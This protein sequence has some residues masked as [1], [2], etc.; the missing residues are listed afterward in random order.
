[1]KYKRDVNKVRPH[2]VENSAGQL[3]CK[4][5]CKIII[6]SRWT[7]VGLASVGL[8]TF[9]YGFFPIILEETG[10]Y[11]VSNVPALIE[12]NPYQTKPIKIDDVE[13]LE[14]S[15]EAGQVVFNTTTIIK[16]STFIYDILSELIL[17]GKIPWHASY[18]DIATIFK[19]A[20]KYANSDAANVDAVTELIASIIARSPKSMKTYLRTALPNQLGA[21]TSD[22]M[23]VPLSSVVHSVNNTVNKITGAYFSEGIQSALVHPSKQVESI[24]KVLRA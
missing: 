13:H 11:M 5:A 8:N 9:V 15:F 17:K 7:D 16:K 19:F 24:E 10:E 18:L 22:V 21:D 4:K 2:F 14:F 20:K 3:V 6:P 1:M 23:F 12:L